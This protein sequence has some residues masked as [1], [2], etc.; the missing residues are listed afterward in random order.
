MS[1][2]QSF[3]KVSQIFKL[4]NSMFTKIA[5][6]NA[7]RSINSARFSPN[8][9][10]IALGLSGGYVHVINLKGERIQDRKFNLQL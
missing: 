9:T 7:V 2:P 4:H 1:P 6:Y 5:G 8:G 10:L 3:L